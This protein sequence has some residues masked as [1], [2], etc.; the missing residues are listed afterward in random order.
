MTFQQDP[1]TIPL[2]SLKWDAIGFGSDPHSR[3]L[4]HIRIGSLDMHLEAW[5]IDQ[6]EED[7]QEVKASTLRADDFERLCAMMDSTFQTIEIDGREY[8]L[9]ATPYGD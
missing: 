7:C 6:E 9:V 3:L 8:V 5:E 2:D 4:A 1:P